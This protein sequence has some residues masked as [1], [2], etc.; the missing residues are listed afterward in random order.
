MSTV[1]QQG[2]VPEKLAKIPMAELTSCPHEVFAKLRETSPAV[3]VESGGY[4]YWVITRYDDVRR[5]LADPSLRRDRDKYRDAVKSARVKGTE[6]RIPNVPR[7][8][9]MSPFYDVDERY[10]Q[11]RAP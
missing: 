3:L 11:L 4:R 6:A 7:A 8:L 5:L 2:K 9:R 1:E 10:H